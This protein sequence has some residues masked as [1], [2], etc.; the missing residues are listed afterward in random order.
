M[1]NCSW[2]SG[3]SRS[4]GCVTLVA[5]NLFF[6]LCIWCHG[7]FQMIQWWKRAFLRSGSYVGWII[8]LG[9]EGS[10][11]LSHYSHSI[12]IFKDRVRGILLVVRIL[13]WFAWEE[14]WPELWI[15]ICLQCRRPWFNS[16]VG[17][18]PWRRDKLPIAGFLGFCGGSDGKESSCNAG[19]QGS[20]PGLGTSPA[21][22]HGN[23]LQYYGLENP[24]GQRSLAGYCPWGVK[25]SDMTEWLSTAHHGYI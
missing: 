1:R 7:S 20:I 22:G 21:G 18:F 10:E 9:E 2:G 24:H 8:I 4:R 23:P 3:P 19:E 13:D 14:K 11:Q 16:W 25:E 15:Y 5:Q 6:S 17:K 12:L